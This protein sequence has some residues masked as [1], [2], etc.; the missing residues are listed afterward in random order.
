VRVR[1]YVLVV[2]LLSLVWIVWLA[3]AT[4]LAKVAERSGIHLV[5]LRGSVWHGQA[6]MALVNGPGLRLQAERLSWQIE[7][8]ALLSGRLCMSFDAGLSAPAAAA[9]GIEGRVCIRPDGR[10]SLSDT[11]LDLPAAQAI[12]QSN[13]TISGDISLELQRLETDSG[14]KLIELSG[15]GLWSDAA[16]MLANGVE[17]SRLNFVSAA[18][19][20]STT[21]AGELLITADNQHERDADRLE[22][23]LSAP[24]QQPQDYIV[25]RLVLGEELVTDSP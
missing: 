1:T 16:M 4:L 2:L 13:M 6:A 3:P 24:L 14:Q 22:L 9:D 11:Q 21:T 18:I 8:L 5:N 19:R 10:V 7:P 23:Q 12:R 15:R 17:S 20:L 25:R